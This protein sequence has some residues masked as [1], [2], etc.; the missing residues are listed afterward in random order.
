MLVAGG[1]D[2]RGGE[3]ERANNPHFLTTL[4][5]ERGY[6]KKGSPPHPNSEWKL[7]GWLIGWIVY[8][9]N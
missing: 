4:P 7:R 9:V 3:E 5:A 1:W 6:S 2:R 8:V